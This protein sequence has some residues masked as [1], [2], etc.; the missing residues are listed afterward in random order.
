VYDTQTNMQQA[1]DDQGL[2]PKAFEELTTVNIVKPARS[3]NKGLRPKAFEKL[4]TI[5]IKHTRRRWL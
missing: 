5:N 3:N 2:R 4:T 1:R